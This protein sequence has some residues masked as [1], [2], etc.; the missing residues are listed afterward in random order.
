MFSNC[1]HK[2]NNSMLIGTAAREGGEE[3]HLSGKNIE[4]TFLS[5]LL[6]SVHCGFMKISLS[7]HV[8]ERVN[9]R[10]TYHTCSPN[11]NEMFPCSQSALMIEQLGL[12]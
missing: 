7:L 5:F 4:S 11:R 9:K 1:P 2:Q 12:P 8:C 10:E 3:L 6:E